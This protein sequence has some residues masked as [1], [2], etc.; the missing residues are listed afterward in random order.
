LRKAKLAK[1][2]ASCDEERW[3]FAPKGGSINKSEYL[4]ATLEGERS[5]R[6]MGEVFGL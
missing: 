5:G 3:C 6:L 1:K 4:G 2:R